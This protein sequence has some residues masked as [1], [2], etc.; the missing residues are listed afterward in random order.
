MFVYSEDDGSNC[1]FVGIGFGQRVMAETFKAVTQLVWESDYWEWV[2][3][4][5]LPMTYPDLWHLRARVEPWETPWEDASYQGLVEILRL[6][7][8]DV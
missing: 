7:Y 1:G 5:G 2:D 3:L 6:E 8:G 4:S